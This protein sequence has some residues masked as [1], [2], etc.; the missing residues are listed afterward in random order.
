MAYPQILL[1]LLESR[2]LKERERSSLLVHAPI[3]LLLLHFTFYPF[4]FSILSIFFLI[5]IFPIFFLIFRCFLS[6]YFSHLFFLALCLPLVVLP[7][8]VAIV[9]YAQRRPFILPSVMSFTVLPLN[10]F[11]PDVGVHPRPPIGLS[12]AQPSSLLCASRATFHSQTKEFCFV[13][14]LS[15]A[16][17]FE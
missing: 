2:L 1:I 7:P 16:F 15:V 17:P 11:C 5:P 9:H 6:C 4:C 8:L 13:F 10:Y 14:L 12:A 3:T